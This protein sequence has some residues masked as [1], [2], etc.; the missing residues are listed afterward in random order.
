MKRGE[1]Y[2]VQLSPAVGS[3]LRDPHPCVVVQSDLLEHPLRPRTIVVPI[4]SRAPKYPLPFVVPLQ[5]PDGGLVR[6]SFALCDQVTRI[7][8]TRVLKS[9]G[10]LSDLA[11]AKIDDALR[12]ALELT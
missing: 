5:P 3:E 10:Q 11:M 8:K 9:T 6:P 7:D 1:I 2:L 12:L 4:T